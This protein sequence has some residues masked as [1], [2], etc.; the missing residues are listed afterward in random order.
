[1]DALP[2]FADVFGAGIIGSWFGAAMFGLTTS[3][4]FFYFTE[5]PKDSVNLKIL[6]SVVWFLNA[7]QAIFMCFTVYH[8]LI[9]SAFNLPLLSQM[10]WSMSTSLMMH[11]MVALLVMIYF[12]AI[13]FNAASGAIL[14]WGLIALCAVAVSLHAAFGIETV[15]DLYKARTFFD[16]HQYSNIAFLPMTATQ[17]GADI[18]IAASLCLVLRGRRS[19]FRRTK[20]IVNTL[21]IY[22]INRCLL[23]AAAA[24][25]ELL[26]L[27]LQPDKM[28][29]VGA[30]F[31]I[32]GLYTNAFLAS[33][34]SRHRIR[35]GASGSSDYQLSNIHSELSAPGEVSR[36]VRVGGS[37][38]AVNL[39]RNIKF[40]DSA[41][42]YGYMKSAIDTMDS[43]V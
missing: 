39:G 25:V 18:I 2:S 26:A 6:V 34:N 17:V 8:Y 40:P 28:W 31:T 30:E 4:V 7:L 29:Y 43:G 12:V 10:I 33:L 13:I 16:L 20:S 9:S 24:L 41:V 21:M 37:S 15:V 38:N 3:Q 19:E 35:D 1:M 32:V 11:L 42:N 27:A 36:P 14:R 5:Y 22:A 23:T